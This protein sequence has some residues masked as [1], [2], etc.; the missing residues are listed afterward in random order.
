MCHD[1]STAAKHN[2]SVA[3]HMQRAVDQVLPFLS[4][5]G[6]E[7]IQAVFSGEDWDACSAGSLD[8]GMHFKKKSECGKASFEAAFDNALRVYGRALP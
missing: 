7:P 2:T 4:S 3:Q 6:K 8:V 1:P 5:R